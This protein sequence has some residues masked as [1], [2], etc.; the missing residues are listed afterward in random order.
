MKATIQLLF[1]R[2]SIITPLEVLFKK[3]ILFFARKLFA[4]SC[5]LITLNCAAQNISNNFQNKTDAITVTTLQDIQFGYFT[6]GS[7]G[8]TVSI[9]ADG[10]RS[11]TGGVIPLNFGNNYFQAIFEIE[12]PLGSIISMAS[13]QNA[14]L[15][16][17]NGGSLS[18]QLDNSIPASPFHTAVTPPAKTQVNVGATLVVGNSSASPPGNYTGNVYVL[19]IVE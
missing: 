1:K 9:S 3:T 5:V 19:F 6:Q 13:G 11:V 18:L 17:S 16:G 8:G 15:N 10:T 14:I 7:A 4:L 2:F 12:A